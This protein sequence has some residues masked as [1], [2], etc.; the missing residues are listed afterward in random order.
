M[1]PFHRVQIR[2]DFKSIS[3]FTEL[4]GE[5]VPG[6]MGL[7]RQPGDHPFEQLVCVLCF[8]GDV[9]R[10]AGWGALLVLSGSGLG[11][12]PLEVLFSLFPCCSQFSGGLKTL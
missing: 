12:W 7:G 10:L 4:S 11:A 2:D 6:P 3:C 5:F 1:K 8:V 9:S